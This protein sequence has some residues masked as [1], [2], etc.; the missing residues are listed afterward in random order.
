MYPANAIAA[1][2]VEEASAPDSPLLPRTLLQI[3]FIGAC[4][5]AALMA[6]RVSGARVGVVISGGNVT[7]ERFAGLVAS[8][9]WPGT[10]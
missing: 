1:K 8:G 10:S 4:A 6:G 7:A 3:A 2:G 5:L 9:P